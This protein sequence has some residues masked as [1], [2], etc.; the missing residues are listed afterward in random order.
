MGFLDNFLGSKKPAPAPDPEFQPLLDAIVDTLG[1]AITSAR[2]YEQTIIPALTLATR[3]FDG[4]VMEIPGPMTTRSASYDKEPFLRA[5]FPTVSEIGVAL[6][7][8]IEVKEMVPRLAQAG[9]RR[10]FALMGMRCQERDQT[11]GQ[12]AVLSDHTLTCVS[13]SEAESRSAIRHAACLRVIKSYNAH[14]D[15]LRQKGK[16][17]PEEWNIENTGQLQDGNAEKRH[18]IFDD[19]LYAEKELQ[20][21]NLLRGLVAWFERPFDQFRV[22]ESGLLVSSGRNDGQGS[23]QYHLPLGVT[24]DRRRWLL[25]LIE[26]SCSEG[27]QALGQE[28]RVHRYLLL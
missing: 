11:V 9:H 7:R 21:D 1:P 13:A 25:A 6:G 5:V 16:L 22:V 10:A 28:T 20:P 2:H 24:A 8:S 23:V 27:L 14:L 3:Y 15:K 19:Y 18:L 12:P 4:Q 17:L 26:F